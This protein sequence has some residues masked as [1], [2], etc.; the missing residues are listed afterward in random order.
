MSK[1][2][3][4]RRVN[5]LRVDI[6]I[7]EVREHPEKDENPAARSITA[8]KHSTFEAVFHRK[9]KDADLVRTEI[10]RAHFWLWLT[11]S[12]CRFTHAFADEVIRA[13]K[14]SEV[15]S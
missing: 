4:R 1:K 5:W 3:V 7:G 14:R 9:P 6:S 11:T 10:G 2:Q 15:W 12:V 13:L 8:Y